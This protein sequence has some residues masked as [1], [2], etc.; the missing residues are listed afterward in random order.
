MIQITKIS[1]QLLSGNV[2]YINAD[3]R[4]IRMSVLCN[5]GSIAITGSAYFQNN[6]PSSIPLYSGQAFTLEGPNGTYVMDGIKIDATAGSA[7][8]VLSLQ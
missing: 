7:V 2:I 8:L 4:V 6:S 3:D 1:T 5:N